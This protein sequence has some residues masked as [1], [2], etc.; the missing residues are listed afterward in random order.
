ML[1]CIKY[2]LISLLRNKVVVFWLLGFTIILGT[3]FYA[4]FGSLADNEEA[5]SNIPVAV[6]EG[7]NPVQGFDTVIEALSEGEDGLLDIKTGDFE[8]ARRLIEAG[9]IC[10][11]IYSDGDIKL[12]LPEGT[13]IK[14]GI[15]RA[16]LDSFKTRQGIVTD[17]AQ[18]HPEKL[19]EVLE[20]ITEE[21]AAYISSSSNDANKDP[22]VQYFYNL[23][24][25][26]GLLGSMMGM[27]CAINHQANLSA[28]GA[29]IEV[30]PMSKLKDIVSS[31]I[32]TLLVHNVFINIGAVYI[33]FILGI[34]FGVSFGFIVII[35]FMSTVIG[36]CMGCFVGSIGTMKDTVK[37]AILLAASLG[38]CFCSGL[39]FGGMRLLIEETFPLFNRINPAAL[40]VDSFYSLCVYEGYE[41]FAENIAVLSVWCAALLI[42]SLIMTRRRKYKSI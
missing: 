11:I 21:A 37:N 4:A 15:V 38:L 12:E 41:R 14:S 31:L 5:F 8:E 40:I 22:Y 1:H 13:D 10:G 6:I 36:N 3:L 34:D 17:V 18:N 24:A 2:E 39:M 35:N 20:S 7:D 28:L 9:E 19:G 32:A 42:G 23:L 33:I 26:C 16:V 29:R 27:Y 25:M 30:S